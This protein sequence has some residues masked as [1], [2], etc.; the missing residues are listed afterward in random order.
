MFFLTNDV[1]YVFDFV[2]ETKSRGVMSICNLQQL[3]HHECEEKWNRFCD[4]YWAKQKHCE[5]E[6]KV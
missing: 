5:K 4:T 6:V 3:D 1:G 2:K